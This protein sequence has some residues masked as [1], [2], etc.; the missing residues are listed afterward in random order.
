MVCLSLKRF[1]V[2]RSLLSPSSEPYGH[3]RLIW[4]VCRP[5]GLVLI[6]RY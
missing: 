4:C 5:R 3:H 1:G 6:D 2:N